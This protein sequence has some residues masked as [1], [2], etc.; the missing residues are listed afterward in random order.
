[1]ITGCIRSG[2]RALTDARPKH[3]EIFYSKTHNLRNRVYYSQTVELWFSV[4]EIT[5]SVKN[6]AKTSNENKISQITENFQIN[7]KTTVAS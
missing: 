7:S 3:E 6:Y 5:V 2:N 1:M 4:K